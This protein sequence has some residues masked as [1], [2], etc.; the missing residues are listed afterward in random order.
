MCVVVAKSLHNQAVCTNIL[1][2]VVF[3]VNKFIQFI[4]DFSYIF[5]H[6]V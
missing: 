6:F 3:F 2:T 1:K 4:Y 5:Y